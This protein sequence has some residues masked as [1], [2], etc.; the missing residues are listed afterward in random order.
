MTRTVIGLAIV[1]ALASQRV[2][3]STS[4]QTCAEAWPKSPGPNVDV[5]N[6]G[7]LERAVRGAR[8]G[9]TIWLADGEYLLREG[10]RLAVP[11]LTLR[12]KSGDAQGRHP[13]PRNGERLGWSGHFRRRGRGD[14]H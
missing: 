4:P 12:G 10:L 13:W 1:I 5:K 2:P 8:S 9:S 6:I 3:T 11:N 7:E 14:G